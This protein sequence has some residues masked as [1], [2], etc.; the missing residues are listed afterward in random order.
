MSKRETLLEIN[1]LRAFA[2]KTG[3]PRSQ[4]VN[5][6]NF[7]IDKGEIVALV[8]ESG[9]GKSVTALSILG[10]NAASI[11]Y[12]SESE[13]RFH[14]ENLLQ[15][16]DRKLR[17]LRGNDI[18][19]IFQ[20]PM[21]SL[22][23]LKKIGKQMTEAL[24]QHKAADVRTARQDAEK[25][26][27]RVGITDPKRQLDNYPY[28][29]SGGMRQRVM[30]AMALLCKPELLIADE[31]TTALD[32]TIQA[33]ILEIMKDL[34]QELDVSI[35]LITHDLGVVAEMADRVVVMYSGQV[36]EEA[37]VYALFEQPLHPYTN[38]L[39]TSVPTLEGESD[40]RIS[41]IRGTV[42][43]PQELPKGCNFYDRCTR[44]TDRCKKEEPLL[45]NHGGRNVA[46]WHP[47]VEGVKDDER[48]AIRN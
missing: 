29:L 12:E 19:M 18:S 48:T 45:T 6:V 30:I 43:S 7:R 27:E 9:C 16:S 24:L 11:E 5:S 3:E 2:E 25:M 34:Q 13:I 1:N 33:Q 21:F 20:D 23:P 38:G 46:C 17:K 47:V 8:G 40:E 41:A 37:D 35:L 31:P 42:P 15:L 36:V 32:V 39:L 22:N 26:I 44:R 14:D 4:L 28:Q 10:L